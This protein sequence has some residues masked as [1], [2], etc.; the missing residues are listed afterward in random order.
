MARSRD[1]WSSP[2]ERRVWLT[3]SLFIAL[4]SPFRSLGSG[5]SDSMSSSGG[6]S[7]GAYF[8]RLIISSIV[9]AGVLFA[10]IIFAMNQYMAAVQTS[11]SRLSS[12]VETLNATVSRVD[13]NLTS[14]VER[15]NNNVS[16]IDREL[17]SLQTK[18][19][20][21]AAAISQIES[22]PQST[23]STPTAAQPSDGD[24]D[25]QIET[26]EAPTGE[27]PTDDSSEPSVVVSQPV[28]AANQRLPIPTSKPQQ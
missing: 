17:T 13:T 8:V 24:A 14:S 20:R 22:D 3:K 21:L 1:L 28:P 5:Q 4:L 27:T 16:R 15:L 2:T 19:G 25:S 10:V 18:S 6:V 7:W 12:N 26:A 9:A 11:V 23:Q